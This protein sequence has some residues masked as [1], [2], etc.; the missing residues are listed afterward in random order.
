MLFVQLDGLELV[1]RLG[2]VTKA[3]S[4]LLNCAQDGLN[5]VAAEVLELRLSE[6]LTLHD[7][8]VG[9]NDAENTARDGEGNHSIVRVDD[10][11]L[12]NAVV[13]NESVAVDEAPVSAGDGVRG[14]R[15]VHLALK[16]LRDV[17]IS[18]TE[19]VDKLIG[20]DVVVTV[21]SLCYRAALKNSGGVLSEGLVAE[22][23]V[24]AHGFV[25]GWFDV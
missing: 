10:D 14:K 7:E 6:I 21:G 1:N 12:G 25:F 18:L 4:S 16:S 9:A 20:I 5:G 2:N 13:L 17:P 8:P 19:G 24:V 15:V 22:G 23:D 3:L 11:D